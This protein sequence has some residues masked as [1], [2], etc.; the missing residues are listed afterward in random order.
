MLFFAALALTAL[1]E[2]PL[3]RV[4]ASAG[5]HDPETVLNWIASII[6]IE[7][8][9]WVA[10]GV[11]GLAAGAWGHWIAAS[12]D[13]RRP[14]QADRF[15]EMSSLISN[16]KNEWLQSFSDG[17]GDYNFSKPNYQV[18]L[19]R[20]VLYA[21]LDEV[22]I[23]APDFSGL[24]QE[25]ANVGH[26]AFM[27]CLEPYAAHGLLKEAKAEAAKTIRDIKAASQSHQRP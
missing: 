14:S 11:L 25:S 13:R 1:L 17:F 12:L 24:D 5:F 6:G 7:A 10:S 9:P 19:R 26:Y 23:Q 3:M 15:A 22:G 18:G 20:K 8:F 27:M 21:K 16:V 4:F 2:P